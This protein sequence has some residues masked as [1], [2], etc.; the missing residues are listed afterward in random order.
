MTK[1]VKLREHVLTALYSSDLMELRGIV[2]PNPKTISHACSEETG[3]MVPLTLKFSST[4][5]SVWHRL[6]VAQDEYLVERILQQ[7]WKYSF[8]VNV[9][10]LFLFCS[11]ATD[12]I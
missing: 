4:N 3:S 12:R 11:K 9:G 8:E 7:R 6:H 2:V 5:G 10:L 1:N